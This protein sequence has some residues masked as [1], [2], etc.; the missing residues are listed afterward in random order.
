MMFGNFVIELVREFCRL[1]W[2]FEGWFLL[3]LY[4]GN[5]YVDL[6]FRSLVWDF[7]DC[8]LTFNC[9]NVG[10]EFWRLV[11]ILKIGFWLSTL[12]LHFS[13]WFG[14]SEVGLGLCR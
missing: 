7:A 5:C 6:E 4:F 2:D 3:S 11:R 10:A 14:I 9:F 1:V 8:F 12:G 13:C